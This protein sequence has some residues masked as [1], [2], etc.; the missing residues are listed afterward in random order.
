MID[1]ASLAS[2]KVSIPNR[3]QARHHIVKLFKDEMQALSKRLQV[4]NRD[5]VPFIF[6]STLTFIEQVC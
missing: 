3:H 4:T 5:I 6:S 1:V 2:L